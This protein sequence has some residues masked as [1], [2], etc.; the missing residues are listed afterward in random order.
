MVLKK[1][2]IKAAVALFVIGGGVGLWIGLKP[3]DNNKLEENNNV[4]HKV[5]EKKK[6][7]K[8][9]EETKQEETKEESS[10]TITVNNQTPTTTNNVTNTAN[11]S[12]AEN[13]SKVDNA[14]NDALAAVIVAES[15]VDNTSFNTAYELVNKVTDPAQAE[16]L[17]NRLNVLRNEVQIKA[18]VNTLVNKVNI[19]TSLDDIQAARLYK[20]EQNL[21]E[22]V[23][24]L[25]NNDLKNQL[26]QS[27]DAINRI[28]VDEQVPEVNIEQNEYA[29]A[30]TITI[31]DY[32]SYT[33]ELKN[34]DN[35]Q[36]VVFNKQYTIDEDGK[37][38]LTITDAAFN[39]TTR[40]FT[41]DSTKPQFNLDEDKYYNVKNISFEEI[42]RNLDKIIITHNDEEVI[43]NSTDSLLNE[44][45]EPL[46]FEEDGE[47]KLVAI[48][49]AN[50]QSDEITIKIDN[51]KPQIRLVG[52]LNE[53]VYTTNVEYS[54]VE[55]HINT[56]EIDGEE[57]EDITA[58]TG[59]INDE[60]EHTIKVVDKAG[61]IT[62]K[63]FEINKSSA[64]NNTTPND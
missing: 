42:D 3:F 47:Y 32:N 21:V 55:D 62:I 12:K 20:Q 31:V 39:K 57:I 43:Y 48:D 36:S 35:N 33:A 37:Y 54:I 63:T 60:G 26:N 59:T 13:K 52:T 22:K 14:Y 5:E 46:F 17:N 51:T 7:D 11:F 1:S 61:N 24:N 50:N 2:V 19:A 8:K 4:K 49:K 58:L 41:I 6:I 30:K 23:Q 64:H 56:I 38:L 25:T 44:D 27:M 53:D 18:S 16:E 9:Q 10:Q 15:T 40:E 29:Q 45:G 34:L 28:L